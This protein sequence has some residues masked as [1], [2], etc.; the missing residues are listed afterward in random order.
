MKFLPEY[1]LH[2]GCSRVCDVQTPQLAK[3]VLSPRSAVELTPVLCSQTAFITTCYT[4]LPEEPFIL[5]MYFHVCLSDTQRMHSLWI[6][7]S[8]LDST[9]QDAVWKHVINQSNNHGATR[10]SPIFPSIRFVNAKN[11]R[12]EHEI[13][14]NFI[15][16]LKRETDTSWDK[17][18]T[19]LA[20]DRKTLRSKMFLYPHLKWISLGQKPSELRE[21]PFYCLASW[22]F[23]KSRERH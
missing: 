9:E 23:L 14:N 1:L 10:F 15:E 18:F 20:S 21:A 3:Q 5:K 6:F 12:N 8:L 2:A 13:A 4:S 7:L 17:S 16:N 22:T 11:V 19:K